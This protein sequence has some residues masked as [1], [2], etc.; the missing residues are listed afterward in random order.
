MASE[1]E[2][3]VLAFNA[4]AIHAGNYALTI[5]HNTVG[6]LSPDL[7]FS[8]VQIDVFLKKIIYCNSSKNYLEDL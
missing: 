5:D 8:L 4:E 6:H 2:R 1:E 3:T 7:V